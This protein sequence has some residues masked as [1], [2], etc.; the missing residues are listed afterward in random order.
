[1]STEQS[2]ETIDQ[3]IENKLSQRFDPAYL[4]VINESGQHSRPGTQT[5]YKVILVTE[6]FAG[7]SRVQRHRDVS[8][9]LETEFNAG[10]HALS[11]KLYTP[12]EW[13]AR[14]G[15]VPPSP[16]CRGGSKAK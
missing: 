11:L 6:A 5:H 3:S 15:A 14:H 7:A 13:E 10:V 9:C 8:A 16:H 4:E 1:M 2:T 12:A